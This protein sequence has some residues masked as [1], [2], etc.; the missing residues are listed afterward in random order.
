M[1]PVPTP[2]EIPM[3]PPSAA[4]P[5]PPP[6][7]VP[8]DG[9]Q[10]VGGYSQPP[11][12]PGG[13]GQPAPGGYG[14]PAP[15]YEAGGYAPHGGTTHY[16]GP[17]PANMWLRILALF[18]DGIAATVLV[19]IVLVPLVI[20]MGDAAF[21]YPVTLLVSLL[22]GV[23][24]TAAPTAMTGKTLGKLICGI[25]VVRQDDP[26]GVPGWGPALIRYVINGILSALSFIG[27]LVNL[28]VAAT[29]QPEHRAVHD[30]VAKTRVIST[31][32]NT[33]GGVIA[34]I[35]AISLIVGVIMVGVLAAIAVPV[36]LNQRSKGVEVQMRTD[37]VK[38]AE[39]VM[40]QRGPATPIRFPVVIPEGTT[41]TIGSA[42]YT[43]LPG[44]AITVTVNP[45]RET[46]CVKVVN[47]E[48]ATPALYLDSGTGQTTAT[49]CDGA[50]PML[51]GPAGTPA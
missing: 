40:S 35:V 30:R 8:V 46:F 24:Y 12:P 36:F 18:L 14:Y 25:K 19:M 4:Y 26:N 34:A 51:N 28:I 49:P 47:D 20:S 32:P 10:P 3:P 29:D 6:P 16:R 41:G 5:P 31:R 2:G 37:A 42:S 7:N 15:A 17:E 38:V 45:D 50:D 13:Y 21:G 9:V 11:A 39:V 23:A 22:L 44:D 27:P 33:S 1:G 48:S 43:P